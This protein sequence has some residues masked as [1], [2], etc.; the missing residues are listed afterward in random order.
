MN[1]FL[2]KSNMVY[3]RDFDPMERI[4]FAA[5]S[6]VVG[7]LRAVVSHTGI[8]AGGRGAL[9]RKQSEDRYDDSGNHSLDSHGGLPDN[10][11]GMGKGKDLPARP[12]TYSIYRLAYM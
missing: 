10:R 4:G 8:V 12:R 3:R 6:L 5:N 11:A 2:A 1:H 9:H 7:H